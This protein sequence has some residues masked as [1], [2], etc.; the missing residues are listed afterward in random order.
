M[1]PDRTSTSIRRSSTTVHA[2]TAAQRHSLFAENADAVVVDRYLRAIDGTT[3]WYDD[4]HLRQLEE[5]FVEVVPAFS[6]RCG[7]AYGTWCD[8]GVSHDVLRRAGLGPS[9]G[10]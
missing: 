2:M 7:I 9:P 10:C 5:A 8:V 3:G 1:L 4:T 6:E